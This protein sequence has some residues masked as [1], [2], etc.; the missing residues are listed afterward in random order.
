[1]SPEPRPCRPDLLQDVGAPVDDYGG[2]AASPA[3]RRYERSYARVPRH[4]TS[5]S[6]R[7]GS[8]ATRRW[9]RKEMQD[10]M[11][12]APK[13]RLGWVPDDVLTELVARYEATTGDP[14]RSPSKRNLVAACY[15]VHGEDFLPLVAFMLAS[16]GTVTNLLGEIRGMLAGSLGRLKQESLPPDEP[17]QRRNTAPDE[18][19][20]VLRGESSIAHPNAVP[21]RAGPAATRHTATLFS[22]EDFGR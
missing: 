22:E 10:C 1:M 14:V 7:G 15:R 18:D 13:F 17:E 9:S 3:D 2:A 20:A 16:R 8:R 5:D 6:F 12:S 19:D 11:A 4:S 21:E